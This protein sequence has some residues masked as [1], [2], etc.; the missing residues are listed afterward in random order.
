MDDVQPEGSNSKRAAKSRKR[1]G[2]EKSKAI[3]HQVKQ[4]PEKIDFVILDFL[5]TERSGAH[6][7]T[8]RDQGSE[9]EKGE[10]VPAEV[11]TVEKAAEPAVETSVAPGRPARVGDQIYFDVAWYFAAARTNAAATDQGATQDTPA[12][13]TSTAKDNT[14]AEPRT[15]GHLVAEV[16]AAP[17]LTPQ[18]SIDQDPTLEA[19]TIE[20]ANAASSVVVAVVVAVVGESTRRRRQSNQKI[21]R[22][23]STW[24]P[25]RLMQVDDVYAEG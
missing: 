4:A 25:R 2:K 19:V 1:K 6:G 16:V 17:I 9:K 15:A 20:A 12:T 18:A 11:K 21:S 3:E 14:T 13:P 24:S 8:I 5:Q 22:S 10:T 7:I 23:G